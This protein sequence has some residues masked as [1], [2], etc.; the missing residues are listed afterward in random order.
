MMNDG[1]VYLNHVVLNVYLFL[2]VEMQKKK[3][4]L[5]DSFIL[6]YLENY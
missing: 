1:E 2:L 3:S 5:F 6:G 4:C